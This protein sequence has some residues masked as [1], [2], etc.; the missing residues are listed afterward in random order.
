MNDFHC[1]RY[2]LTRSLVDLQLPVTVAT[3]PAL[4]ILNQFLPKHYPTFSPLITIQPI[5]TSIAWFPSIVGSFAIG[6]SVCFKVSR[7]INRQTY[8]AWNYNWDE[9]IML[10][11]PLKHP[12]HSWKKN[13]GTNDLHKP[14]DELRPVIPFQP[15]FSL[16]TAGLNS[17]WN[18]KTAQL[19]N[20]TPNKRRRDGN[21]ILLYGLTC[22]V[23]TISY[24]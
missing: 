21:S 15:H 18:Q 3:Q 9:N 14:L 13:H 24:I 2:Y 5:W 4:C 12:V 22:F 7:Q 23:C 1:R 8:P 19:R 16:T 17:P 6:K 20:D 10:I 11:I